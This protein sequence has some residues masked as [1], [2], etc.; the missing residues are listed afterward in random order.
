MLPD[1][2]GGFC[3]AVKHFFNTN[4]LSL[5]W[6]STFIALIPKV[7]TPS[8]AKDYRPTN[9][10]NVCYKI[11]SKILVNRINIVLS[12][13]ESHEQS[14]FVS[15]RDIIDN[16]FIAQEVLHSMGD[17]GRKLMVLKLDI[18]RAYEMMT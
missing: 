14:V 9:L 5:Q 4:H 17:K 8:S 16:V 11:V 15:D 7:K 12:L 2:K 10:C 1:N 13:F 3:A 6:K 18:E